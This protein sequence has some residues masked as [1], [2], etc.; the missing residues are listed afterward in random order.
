MS[1]ASTCRGLRIASHT[2]LLVA[3]LV[4]LCAPLGGR[5]M[6]VVPA[7]AAQ[8]FPTGAAN[9]AATPSVEI[10]GGRE[11][12]LDFE[13]VVLSPDGT[14][15]AGI[16]DRSS[17]CLFSIVDEDSRCRAVPRNGLILPAS[18]VWA[19]ASSAIAFSLD[20]LPTLRNSDIFIFDIARGD[21]VNLTPDPAPAKP[22][23]ETES[24]TSRGSHVMRPS[25]A[26]PDSDGRP[27]WMDVFP[28]WSP[29][30][31][32][33]VFARHEIPDGSAAIMRISRTGGEAALA[34][35]LASIEIPFILGPILWPEDDAII[36][37]GTGSR[38]GLREASLKTGHV[39]LMLEADD[40]DLPD[41]VAVS[42]SADGE[43][44]SVYSLRNVQRN[45]VEGFFGLV[46]R[47]TGEILI[48]TFANGPDQFVKVVPRFGPEA[49]LLAATFG[50]NPQTLHVWDITTA[51]PVAS[52]SLSGDGPDIDFLLV[53]LSW[54]ANGTILVPGPKESAQ[55]VEVE[56][57]P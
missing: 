10:N 42:A 53:G 26:T 51:R 35:D 16:E 32:E 8:G 28:A 46:E 1:R 2:A 38:G 17:I 45:N 39:R 57:D 12:E 30:G 5:G 43:W 41:A 36:F 54:A 34:V 18:I 21:L 50:G 48:F 22:D 3:L 33:L 6:V 55:I 40:P 29:D 31:S 23:G 4:A 52:F 56:V 44:L 47:A 9:R 11:I 7:R 15:I 19:P 20:A 49:S 27:F 13:P 14:S 37:S 24:P 25:D